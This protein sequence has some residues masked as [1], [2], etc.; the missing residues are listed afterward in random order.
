MRAI[1]DDALDD[2]HQHAH[3][4]LDPNDRDAHAVADARE[5][6]SGALHLGRV[7]PAQAFVG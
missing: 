2:A 6:V 7:E 1:H 3:D 5:Q 4:V